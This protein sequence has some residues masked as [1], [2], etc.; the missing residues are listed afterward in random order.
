MNTRNVR[1]PRICRSNIVQALSNITLCMI[2]KSNAHRRLS[3]N[4]HAYPFW[5][6]EY[7]HTYSYCIF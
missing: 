4:Q 7:M 2:F 3:K 5:I 6:S 1:F